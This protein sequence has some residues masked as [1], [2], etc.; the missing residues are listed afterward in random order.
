MNQP[1]AIFDLETAPDL[2]AL[3]RLTPP[4][5]PSSS[6]SSAD[7]EADYWRAA[8]AKATLNPA[9]SCICAIGLHF[10]GEQPLLRTGDDEAEL[11]RWFWRLF[12]SWGG[13]F[14]YWSGNN[15]K[16]CFDPRFLVV[17]SWVRR[18]P[19]PRGAYGKPPGW[20]LSADK[21]ID[22]APLYLIGAEANSFCSA[23]TAAKTLGLLGL[24]CGWGAIRDKN[25]LAVKAAGFHEWLASGDPERREAALDYL[26]NDLAIERA[27]A[28][29]ILSGK[30][31]AA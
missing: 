20:S 12:E 24:D 5:V 11:L 30:E 18:V 9:T 2:D 4:Y 10:P 29:V 23:N 27:I 1:P 16:G 25:T 28:D 14:A 3:H 7:A 31:V 22:L 15:S 21:W 13:N 8:R 17:R 19:V 26:R 6:K